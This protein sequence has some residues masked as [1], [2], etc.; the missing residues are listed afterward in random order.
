MNFNVDEMETLGELTNLIIEGYDLSGA[1][2]EFLKRLDELPDVEKAKAFMS[3][4]FKKLRGIYDLQASGELKDANDDFLN[5]F[6]WYINSLI[7]GREERH[8]KD[9]EETWYTYSVGQTFYDQLK[10][11][12]RYVEGS[13]ESGWDMQNG[14][15]V[16]GIKDYYSE[17]ANR[18]SGYVSDI[19]F[20]KNSLKKFEN[21]GYTYKDNPEYDRDRSDANIRYA[22]QYIKKVKSWIQDNKQNIIDAFNS[23]KYKGEYESLADQKKAAE[24]QA[25]QAQAQQ[26]QGQQGQQPVQQQ[27]QQPIQ[28]QPQPQPQQNEGVEHDDKLRLENIV[29][30]VFLESMT[31]D[32]RYDYF[33]NNWSPSDK[34]DS[35]ENFEKRRENSRYYDE[36]LAQRK[37][38]FF[39]SSTNDNYWMEE[40]TAL[41]REI[42]NLSITAVGIIKGYGRKE[43]ASDEEVR[44]ACINV[45]KTCDQYSNWVYSGHKDE[46][47][48]EK[49]FAEKLSKFVDSILNMVDGVAEDAERHS[50]TINYNTDPRLTAHANH[51]S[52]YARGLEE[53]YNRTPEERTNWHNL[54]YDEKLRQRLYGEE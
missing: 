26:Q 36:M 53:Y 29:E 21:G 18:G 6:L 38:R 30:S 15:H 19:E 35:R 14:E 4:L 25:R 2:P 49:G 11:V 5:R 8:G 54:P 23:I 7:N 12:I 22:R 46:S 34:L 33:A 50:Y 40:I 39:G 31:D 9:Q 17:I 3:E 27:A 37:N 42:H 52:Y 51:I 28:Q 24:E 1:S 32:E 44:Q 13:T 41:S 47:I 43:G 20:A 48:F 45:I 10:N 16:K